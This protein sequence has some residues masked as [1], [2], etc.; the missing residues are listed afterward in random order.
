M[1]CFDCLYIASMHAV[2]YSSDCFPKRNKDMYIL[3]TQAKGKC[4]SIVSPL[5]CYVYLENIGFV[6]PAMSMVLTS[7]SLLYKDKVG[8]V[9]CM[10]FIDS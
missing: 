6:Y 7:P 10:M 5:C 4:T 8:G 9:C 3:Y 1:G 2:E